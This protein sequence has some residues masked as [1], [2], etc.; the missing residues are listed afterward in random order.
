MPLYMDEG[1]AARDYK[2]TTVP[3][4]VLIDRQGMIRRVHR[5]VPD[6]DDL[7]AAIQELLAESPR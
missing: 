6:A 1:G 5:G 7:D 3:H 2:V 4:M